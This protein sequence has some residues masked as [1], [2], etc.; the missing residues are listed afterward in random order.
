MQ[1]C[2]QAFLDRRVYTT[3]APLSRFDPAATFGCSPQHL[4][5]DCP[6]NAA[7]LALADTLTEYAAQ[8]AAFMADGVAQRADDDLD[9]VAAQAVPRCLRTRSMR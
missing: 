7:A 8:L 4:P 1:Q 5:A 6:E 9:A 3:D 2:E